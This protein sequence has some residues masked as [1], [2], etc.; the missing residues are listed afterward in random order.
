MKP[1]SEPDMTG[2]QVL[3]A[4]DK[5]KGTL[6]ARQA[7]DAIAAV[8]EGYGGTAEVVPVADGG[9]GTVDAFGGANR[10]SQVTGP[11]GTPVNAQWRLSPDGTAIIESAAAS[12]LVIAGGAERNNPMGA[13]TRGTGE[14]IAEALDAKAREVLV[15]MGGSASTDGGLGALDALE[16]YLPF[17]RGHVQVITD[18]TTP[19]RDAAMV[20]GLQKGATAAQIPIL[21]ERLKAIAG[22]LH[23]SFGVDVWELPGSGASGGLSGGLAAAGASLV[24]GAELIAERLGLRAHLERCDLVVTGEGQFDSTSLSGKGPGLVAEEARRRDIPLLV[25]AGAIAPEVRATY[26]A[27]SLVELV[28]RDRALVD[29]VGSIEVAAAEGLRDVIDEVRRRKLAGNQGSA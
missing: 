28:G 4:P 17:R 20:F 29:P 8:V 2:I 3:I 9:E 19:F 6:S 21:T 22:Q 10:A 15:G 18:V 16:S 23:E 14:L 13:T 27:V 11:L 5:F 24:G 25:I 12:G 1:R 7:A 26:P